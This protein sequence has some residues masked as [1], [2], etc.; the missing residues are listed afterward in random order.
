[1]SLFAPWGARRG[2]FAAR[3]MEFQ[4]RRRQSAPWMIELSAFQT[5]PTLEG[6]A[7]HPEA[8][9]SAETRRTDQEKS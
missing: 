3:M 7:W 4:I 6:R 2:N 1:M 8:K 9:A 5:T